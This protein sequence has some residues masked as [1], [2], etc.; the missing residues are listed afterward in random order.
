MSLVPTP[1]HPLLLRV[2]NSIPAT[3]KYVLIGEASHGTEEFYRARG[4][5]T[6]FLIKQRGF[7]AVAVEADFPDAFRTNL[8]CRGLNNDN[9]PEEA[10]DNFV[11]FPTF[12]WR[13]T[14]VRDFVRWLRHHN[15]GIP[16]DGAAPEKAGFYGIDLY[17]MHGSAKRVIEF[18]QG[19]DGDAAQR[20]TVRYHCFDQF[21]EDAQAYAMATALL[22]KSTCQQAC[23]ST[24][25]EMIEKR[26][27]Y[28][29]K[30]DGEVGRE[31]AFEATCNAAVVAGA[32][33]GVLVYCCHYYFIV[34]EEEEEE[35][36][37]S[38]AIELC[39]CITVSH[40]NYTLFLSGILPKHVFWG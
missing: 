11:R 31:R 33:V 10:L 38:Y 13:N 2:C 34:E 26:A 4:E 24:L 23:V 21:G 20:A 18:L 9:T 29:D 30:V 28:A 37:F 3:A 12:M 17:S 1:H 35:Y 15:D 14:A 16:G 5:I 27:V 25:K 40:C 36:G 39:Y 8:Y 32:E 6:K 22:R 7:N 19:I